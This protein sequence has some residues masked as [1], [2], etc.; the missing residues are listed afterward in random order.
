MGVPVT[1]LDKYNPAQFNIL[2]GI[3]RYACIQTQYTNP[4]GTYGTDVNGKHTYFRVLIQKNYLI[5]R[6]RGDKEWIMFHHL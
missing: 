6:K 5:K 4:I 3:G 1:F 2:N